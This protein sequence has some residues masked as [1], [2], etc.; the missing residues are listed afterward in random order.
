MGD[1]VLPLL[2]IIEH[3]T[4][5]TILTSTNVHIQVNFIYFEA[6]FGPTNMIIYKQVYNVHVS[7][8]AN[9]DKRC[10][11]ICFKLRRGDETIF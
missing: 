3:Q 11:F 6:S 4:K 1:G 5:L 8:F 9:N 2:K 10:H 7:Y